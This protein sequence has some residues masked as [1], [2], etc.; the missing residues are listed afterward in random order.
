MRSRLL[1]FVLM[2]AFGLAP[3]CARAETPAQAPGPP[4]AV[5]AETTPDRPT[6][7]ATVGVAAKSGLR[8]AAGTTG[9]MSVDVTI[10]AGTVLSLRLENDVGSSTS[11]VEDPVRARLRLPVRVAGAT[12]LPAGTIATG[13]VTSARRSGKVKGRATVSVSFH[14]LVTPDNNRYTVRTTTVTR[15]APGTKRK[16]ALKIG[17]PAAGGAVV[18]GLLGGKKGAAIGGAGGGGAGTAVVLSTRGPEVHLRPGTI[19]SVRLKAPLTVR[20]SP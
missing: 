16:D 7:D 8:Q 4:T 13:N 5:G 18:G 12:V 6:S 20:P 10:P 3:A 9:I 2:I 1:R 17:V 11:Q 15:T 19:V 14:E